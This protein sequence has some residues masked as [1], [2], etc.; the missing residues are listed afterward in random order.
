MN[1]HSFLLF[2]IIAL[3]RNELLCEEN[4]ATLVISWTQSVSQGASLDHGVGSNAGAKPY[5]YF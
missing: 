1:V 2:C 4:K 3:K 5:S